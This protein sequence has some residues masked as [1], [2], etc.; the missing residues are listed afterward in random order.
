MLWILRIVSGRVRGW[1]LYVAILL[2]TFAL[3]W[4]AMAVFEPADAEIVR[5][6]NYW[7]WYVV[8]AFTVGYG[9]LYPESLGGRIAAFAVMATTIGVAAA[10][11]NHVIERAA[12]TKSTLMKGLAAVERQDHIVIVGHVPDRTIRLVEEF[13]A[14]DV[15][16]VICA[17][18]STI[19]E[20]PFPGR[21][22]VDFVRGSLVDQTVFE[23][24]SLGA[25]RSVIVDTID[26]DDEKAAL[27]AL[28]IN[29][30]YPDQ[31][32]VVAVSDL[33]R[34]APLLA[35][36]GPGFE[37]VDWH[38][39]RLI[40]DAANDPGISRFYND[41]RTNA[42]STSTHSLVLPDEAGV[43]TI[44]DLVVPMKEQF[45]ASVCALGD[46]VEF[47]N[48]PSVDTSLTPG[49]TLYYIADQRLSWPDVRGA[50]PSRQGT[51]S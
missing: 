39:Y 36:F 24:A 47:F 49:M 23:R 19:T 51:T 42:T 18:G 3:S 27:R 16:V 11:I 7:W 14:V 41:I 37:C 13:E 48:N 32:I 50:L 12:A 5:P 2:V 33:A 8:T 46:A 25:A 28:V 1:Q 22:G 31:H 35:E 26:G 15:P 43:Y 4:T 45:N 17:V 30:R 44:G 9:D 34:L 10:L 21:E 38:D 6:E 29:R 40:A 20:N